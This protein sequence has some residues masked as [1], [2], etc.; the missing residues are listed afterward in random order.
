MTR[1]NYGN[2]AYKTYEYDNQD[3]LISEG[4]NGSTTRT[5]LYDKRGNVAQI[6]DFITNVITKFQYDLIGRT[7]GLKSSDGQAMNFIYDKYNRLSLSKWTKGDMSLSTGYIYGD[8]SVD[9]QKTG[10][11]YGVNLNGTQKLGY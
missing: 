10:L 3:R 2:G 11:I 4:A 6:N 8:N 5:Y 9:G 7:I 1:F